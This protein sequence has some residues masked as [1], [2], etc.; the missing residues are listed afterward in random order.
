MRQGKWL[1]THNFAA[2]G[3]W[4]YVHMCLLLVVMSKRPLLACIRWLFT[5]A[6]SAEPLPSGSRVS[7]IV[8]V[9]F[10]PST[11]QSELSTGNAG[12]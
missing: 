2:E 9:R 3:H 1:E 4:N 5:D 6:F 10:D 11:G 7:M 12:R 8:G